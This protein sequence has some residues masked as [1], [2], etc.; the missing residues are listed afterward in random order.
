M[1]RL[2]ID[3]GTASLGWAIFDDE[4]LRDAP[5]GA[6]A[7]PKIECGVIVFPEG[8][9]RDKSDNLKSPAA[10]RRQKR[11]ARRLIY[12]RKLRKF[13]MLRALMDA[14][15]CPLSEEGLRAWKEQGRYPL[16]DKAFMQWLRSDE[17]ANPYAARAAA[18][19][20]K[21]D[22]LTLGRAFYHLAQRRGFKSSKKEQLAEREAE[23]G[24][25]AAKRAHKKSE[26]SQTKQEIDALTS[27]F[28]QE[29]LTLGQHFYRLFK[30]NASLLNGAEK[31]AVTNEAL[32]LKIIRGRRIGRKEHYEKEFRK[33]AETQG[34]DEETT[35]RFERIL[36]YQ[37]PLRIQRWTVGFCPLEKG[38]RLVGP[39]GKEVFGARKRRCLV[40]HPE[41]EEY[42]ALA[43]LNNLRI[44]PHEAN[45]PYVKLKKGEGRPLTVEE[46]G[47][48][49]AGLHRKTPCS[50]GEL[51]GLEK[52]KRRLLGDVNLNYRLSDDA[53]VM[54]T[55][56]AF[57][58]L[59]LPKEQWQMALNMLVDSDDLSKVEDWAAKKLALF[60]KAARSFAAT[61]ISTERGAYSLCAI[62]KIMPYLK[63]GFDLRKA[64]F[65]ANLK[66]VIPDFARNEEAVLAGLDA[67]KA[68]READR[69]RGEKRI[70]PL[71]QWYYKNYLA[72]AWGVSEEAF[73][74]LYVDVAETDTHNPV[75]PPVEMGAIRNPLAMRSLTVLRRL[76]N[77]LRREG[78]IDA[79]T[80]VFIELARTVNSANECRAIEML[81]KEAQTER[82]EARVKLEELLRTHELNTPV[83]EDMILRYRLWKEQKEFSVYTGQPITFKEMLGGDIEHT[84][85]R[86]RGGTSAM[87][88]LTLCEPDYNRKIKSGR[89]PSECPN[90]ENEWTD[91]ET[92]RG[93]PALLAS[94]PLEKWRETIARLEKTAKPRRGGDPA[95]F[96]A[97]RQA[98]LKTMKELRYWKEKVRRFT[99]AAES[100]AEGGFM[101]RQ[102]VDT[103]I[104]ATQAVR[105]LKSRY[106][107][108]FSR[109]GTVT[110]TARK[111]W[112]IQKADE[113][114]DRDDHIHHAVDACVIAALDVR[115]FADFCSALKG[116][117]DYE[118]ADMPCPFLEFAQRINRATE[119]VLVRH[120]PTNRQSLPI[121]RRGA[122]PPQA[123]CANIKHQK[124]V[125]LGVAHSSAVRGS[126]HDDTLYGCILHD[127]KEVTV[128]RKTISGLGSDF[129]KTVEQV[130]DRKVKQRLQEQI[131]AYKAQGISASALAD[132][133]YF[134]ASG[135]P[136]KKIRIVVKKPKNPKAIRQQAFTGKPVYGSG[137][138]ALCL[139]IYRDEKGRPAYDYMTLLDAVK[140]KG[141]K[142]K[143]YLYAIRPNLMVLV[144][145][146]KPEELKALSPQQ[147]AKRL[148]R[149][150]QVDENGKV[151]LYYHREARRKGVLQENLVAMGK[152]KG[153]TSKID[154]FDPEPLLV[155]SPST[156]FSHCLFESEHF[157][158]ALDGCITW[159]LRD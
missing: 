65:C 112:G 49:L 28:E 123:V 36:F 20:E 114:K 18:A 35:H 139:G 110:A 107:H 57:E 42:R 37:R 1:K 46:R 138:D 5:V 99:L 34:L 135:I 12:R 17:E 131:A 140:G 41:F 154:Y 68:K 39:D 119:A 146:K 2:G 73:K 24:N 113:E 61:R 53:P 158:I 102:L 120:L 97:K 3:L 64:T 104:I 153:G 71:E 27:E 134:M 79:Q 54:P 10:E 141:G 88:N 77:A 56:A 152:L 108:V 150:R 66:A 151:Y 126:L 80:R 95:V 90:F 124:G 143:D 38:R 94:L 26:A 128:L 103:G 43:L 121:Y 9:D 144:Y 75:L 70:E 109:N 16:D 52:K 93:Y 83:S 44:A 15:M 11:A 19:T 29:E 14:G 33:I 98:Y 50:L 40:S 127:G 31:G 156:W 63:R 7:D 132:Q 111:A 69:E 72:G 129:E 142:S 137:S 48:V 148:Y 116:R 125:E 118:V 51:F 13:H 100:V 82:S 85:P 8:L 6:L 92:G 89:L 45:S 157:E 133:S 117:E 30:Q 25:D 60:P 115:T 84:I 136:I 32:A 4:A 105:F 74:K 101:P 96:A 21:V 55:T 130:V 159:R 23:E 67:A 91:H 155:L 81:Q 87:E 149:V 22:P 62:R 47:V 106:E 145:D 78:K 122:R 147:L 76:V 86:S 58:S 59:A